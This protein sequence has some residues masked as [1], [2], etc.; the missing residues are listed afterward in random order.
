MCFGPEFQN[1]IWTLF[2]SNLVS[3]IRTVVKRLYAQ[4]DVASKF[5]YVVILH[6]GK[7]RILL[8]LELWL[9]VYKYLEMFFNLTF[10]ARIAIAPILKRLITNSFWTAKSLSLGYIYCLNS[11]SSSTHL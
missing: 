6:S 7:L 11:K 1:Q 4:T 3:F 10:K 2:F 9:D 8:L 5:D